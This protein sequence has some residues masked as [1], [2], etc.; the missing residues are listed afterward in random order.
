MLADLTTQASPFHLRPAAA[1]RATPRRHH[2]P[3]PTLSRGLMASSASRNA[4]SQARA[5]PSTWG[6]TQ[7]RRAVVQEEDPQGTTT[8]MFLPRA[9]TKRPVTTRLPSTPSLRRT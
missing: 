4:V 8:L 2:G 9:L 7:P 6:V 3:A 5:P 1:C